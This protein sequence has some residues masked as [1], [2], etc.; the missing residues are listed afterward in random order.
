MFAKFFCIVYPCCAIT[1]SAL[2][3][4][5]YDNTKYSQIRIFIFPPS[6]PWRLLLSRQFRLRFSLKDL[7]VYKMKQTIIKIS[8]LTIG[9]ALGFASQFTP[10][11]VLGVF[12]STLITSLLEMK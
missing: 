4:T 6:I 11:V 3:E 8:L 12:F 7:M 9:L 10:E 1:N 2:G 5:E